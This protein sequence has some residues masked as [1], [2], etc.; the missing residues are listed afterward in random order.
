M[1]AVLVPLGAAVTWYALNGTAPPARPA[2]GPKTAD[3]TVPVMISEARREDVPVFLTGLGTVTAYNSVLI[4]SRVDGQILKL[5]FSEGQ[6]VHAG[7]TLVEIDQKPL[8]AL[9][10]QAQAGMAKDQAQLANARLDLTRATQLQS[11]GSVTKQQFDAARALVDQLDASTKVDEAVIDA[12]E[13]QLG[14]TTIRTPIDGR[15]GTRLV[16]S[17]N[18]VR[19]SDTTGIVTVNQ[20]K[21]IFV[22]F[23]LPSDTL[24]R[25]RA[26]MKAG[27]LSVTAVDN[28]GKDLATGRLTVVDNHVDA[29]TATVRYK[30]DFDNADEALWPGQFVSV[31]LQ[32]DMRQS[33][34]TVPSVAIEHGPDGAFVYVVD[35][36]RIVGKRPI[37]AGL[38]NGSVTVVDEG[39]QPGEEVITDGQYRVQAGTTVSILPTSATPSVPSS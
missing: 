26:K 31:R 11:S 19:A 35:S 15:V 17:G 14:Y 34:I 21:P 39:L 8:K 12:A 23:D 25:V 3:A 10:S 16:D 24:A 1:L 36:S 6:E 22:A 27:D 5:D 13:V 33:V 32:L 29:A 20:I 38:A 18:L 30:A 4:R 2:A 37:V 7:D 9:L 28:H